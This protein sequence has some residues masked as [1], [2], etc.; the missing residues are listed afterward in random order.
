MSQEK[1][2]IAV[3]G[4]HLSGMTLNHQLTSTG[5]SLVR[6]CRTSGEYRLYALPNTTPP[7]PALVREPGFEGRGIEVEIWALDAAAFGQFVA[8]IPSPLGIGKIT[9]EDGTQVSGFLSET[10]ATLGSLEVTQYGGWRNYLASL[11]RS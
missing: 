10:Y 8:A 6:C 9:L 3:V 4:A 1:L 2:R 5:G 7:K 11:V